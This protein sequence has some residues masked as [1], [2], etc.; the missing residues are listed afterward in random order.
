MKEN[1]NDATSRRKLLK[2]AAVGLAATAGISG[3]TMAKT[4]T[5]DRQRFEAALRVLERTGDTEKFREMLVSQGGYIAT[6]DITERKPWDSPSSD[7]VTTEKL[8]QG[9]CTV[10][11]TMVKYDYCSG[12]PWVTF[13]WEHTVGYNWYDNDA[14]EIP[15]DVASLGWEHSDFELVWDSW[16]S[17]NGSYKRKATTEYVT[18]D[19]EDYLCQEIEDETGGD[20]TP[21]GETFT[22]KDYCACQLQAD[23][24]TD[25]SK[26][27][28]I[29]TYQHTWNQTEVDS[30]SIDSSGGM[31][32]TLKNNDYKWNTPL[33]AAI[34]ESEAT[35]EPY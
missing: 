4:Q 34:K 31:S 26:R 19:Y 3:S 8:D 21:M 17:G 33:Q 18:F 22:Q 2:S 6:R 5:S 35:C 12:D 16:Y 30:V 14:G 25:A 9:D 28:V 29:G 10:S 15:V 23:A 11:M 7:E 24:E 1:N 27:K 13:N 20:C 32:V